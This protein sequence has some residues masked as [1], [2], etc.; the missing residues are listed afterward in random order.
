[1][2]APVARIAICLG[3]FASGSVAACTATDKVVAFEAPA[4]NAGCDGGACGFVAPAAVDGAA[5]VTAPDAAPQCAAR[6]CPPPYAT[7]P[8]SRYACDV[9][10]DADDAN[11]GA[12]GIVCP[13]GDAVDQR[14]HAAW[15]CQSTRCVMRCSDSRFAD[16][17]GDAHDGCETYLA[18]CDT[19]NCGGCGITCAPGVP[20]LHGTC[21]CPFGTTACGPI[22]KCGDE[23]NCKETDIDPTNCGSCGN[24]CPPPPDEP[25]PPH[26][27]FVPCERGKCNQED[28]ATG[29]ADCNHDLKDGCE[30]NVLTD[31]DNCGVC[32]ARCGAGQSCFNGVCL[33]PAGTVQC[34]AEQGVTCASL[35]DDPFNC[36]ACR[37]ECPIPDALLGEAHVRATCKLG[38]CGTACDEGYAD[39]D[40]NVSNGCETYVWSDPNNCGA[41]GV[42]CDIGGGQPCIRGQCALAPCT[43]TVPR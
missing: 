40:G 43:P 42:R 16:C 12:C 8:S 37:H 1:V 32:G 35:D 14:Y 33:C 19:S 34:M 20:C 6:D 2:R 7:C 24:V 13:S 17:N 39:C 28:C 10:L 41:C 11:C 27:T 15:S 22:T 9:D 26:M 29:Y 23:I 31:N 3:I 36:G 18:G 38:Q 21:G 5:P 30:I 4:E 25:L